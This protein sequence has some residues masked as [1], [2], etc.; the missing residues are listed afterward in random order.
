LNDKHLPSGVFFTK[1]D[2]D[3]DGFLNL[4]EWSAGIDSIIILSP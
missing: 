2:K 3:E 1:I 4:D